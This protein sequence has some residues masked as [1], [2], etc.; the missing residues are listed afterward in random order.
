[1]NQLGWRRAAAVTAFAAVLTACSAQTPGVE[2]T[3]KLDGNFSAAFGPST[4]LS[5]N[6]IPADSVTVTWVT[7]STCR[8]TGCVATATE[9]APDDAGDPRPPTMVFD[10]VDEHWVSVREVPSECVNL[11]GEPI[12]VSGWQTYVLAPKSDGTLV[13]TYTNRSSVGGACHNST[14]TVTLTRTGDADS[15]VE[16][17]DPGAQ[18]ARK[19]SPAAALWGEYRQVQTNPQS[20]QVYPPTSYA[21]NTQCLRSGDRCLSYFVDPESKA[22]LV[23]TFAG[24]QWT[25]TSAPIDSTC[26]DGGAATSILTGEFALPQQLSDPISTLKGTQRTA[27]T[28]DC[29]G[30]LTL[31]VTLD[32]VGDGRGRAP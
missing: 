29:G 30:S 22:I 12:T 10:F 2:A 3:A 1:V 27:Q 20:G 26:P 5:G 6:D 28:G 21:G 19:S 13:G 7:R 15:A 8:D 25:S 23:M 31:D 16:V 4:T 9:V 14:Q 32:R 24:G 17:A 18:P 11:K